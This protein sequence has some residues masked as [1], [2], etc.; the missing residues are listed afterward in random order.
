MHYSQHTMGA[1]R[2]TYFRLDDRHTGQAWTGCG[3]AWWA[4]EVWCWLNAK[5]RWGAKR[6]ERW[7]CGKSCVLAKT[8]SSE[9]FFSV[10]IFFFWQVFGPIHYSFITPCTDLVTLSITSV[11][12]ATPGSSDRKSLALLSPSYLA[13]ALGFGDLPKFSFF[14]FERWG[15][16]KI[17][18]ISLAIFWTRYSMKIYVLL[19]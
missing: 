3:P 4:M 10:A 2:C 7:V 8:V 11:D 17:C 5:I 12:R 13:G 16:N 15:F 1:F 18:S 19:L 14:L 6:E 9:L